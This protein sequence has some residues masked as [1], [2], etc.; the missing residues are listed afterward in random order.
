[1]SASAPKQLLSKSYI[2]YSL[3]VILTLCALGLLQKIG[4]DTLAAYYYL[5]LV[6]TLLIGVFH[7]M[8]FYRWTGTITPDDFWKGALFTLLLLLLSAA[9][10][11]ALYYFLGGNNSFISC[12]IPFVIPYLCW[13]TYRAFFSIPGRQFKLWHYPVHEEMPDLDM[14]DLSR[15]EV[16]Q[17]VFNKNPLETTQTNFTSKAPL[18]MPLGVLFFIF[19]NDYNEKNKQQPIGFLDPVQSPYGWLFYRRK[20]WF[21]R[22]HYFDPDLSFSDNRIQPNEQIFAVRN[23]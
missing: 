17:F 22:K 8:Y 6:A 1:M 16:V 11:A 4:E 13:Q 12:L 20:K 21:G 23:A 7:A 3:L 10:I 19:I 9:G 5:A 2:L 15:I 14:I 18:N